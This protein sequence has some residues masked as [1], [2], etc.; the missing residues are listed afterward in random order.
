MILMN[1]FSREPQDLKSTMVEA[2]KRVFDSGWYILGNELK[3]LRASK[4]ATCGTATHSIGVGNG[5]DAI[6]THSSRWIFQREM[7]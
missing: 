3:T 4:P 1:D 5:M 2:A 6:E 7:R